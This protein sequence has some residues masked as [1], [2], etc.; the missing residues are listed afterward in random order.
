MQ[1]IVEDI[2]NQFRYGS[3]VIQ[4]ILVNILVYV[5]DNVLQ[6]LFL[7]VGKGYAYD[8]LAEWFM[9]SAA[10]EKLIL[11]PWSVITYMFL[12]ADLWHL[13]FNMYALYI[14]GQIIVNYLGNRKILPVFILGG[15]VGALT[16]VVLFNFIPALQ[17]NLYTPML[18]A[19]AGVMAIVLAAATLQPEHELNILFIGPV[20]IKYIALFFIL[21]DLTTITK[22]NPGGHIAH[23]GGAVFGYFFIRQLQE[24]K[25]W[26]VM[27]NQLTEKL[28]VFFRGLLRK[29][30]LRAHPGSGNSSAK[31]TQNKTGRAPGASSSNQERL[32]SILDKI[33]QSGYE[34]LTREEKEFLFKM[35]K[36]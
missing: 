34:S 16:C 22:S 21:L 8:N 30:T 36:D 5:A 26:S 15:I 33:A 17:P 2:K 20:R 35:S 29:N 3:M 25:D 19:S 31:F 32:D 6:L 18:G 9:V 1:S 11:K 14:F 28:L 13:G 7:L 23:L 12:H 4:L 10:P 24:G 27:F